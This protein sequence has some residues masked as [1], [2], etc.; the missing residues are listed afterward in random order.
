MHG[1]LQ[2]ADAPLPGGVFGWD[3]LDAGT[4][5]CGK[6][7]SIETASGQTIEIPYLMARGRHPGRRL[8]STGPCMAMR[9]MVH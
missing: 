9:S 7:Q 2:T 6:F 8:G 4:R 3:H 1:N 5:S